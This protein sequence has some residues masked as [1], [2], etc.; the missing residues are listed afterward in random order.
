MNEQ[1]MKDLVKS[2]L[3]R[4]SSDRKVYVLSLLAHNLTISARGVYSERSDESE[5]IKK[6]QSLNEMQH[7]L[8][9]QLMYLASKDGD[10]L[11]DD[12]FTDCLYSFASQGGSEV[13][14]TSAL[15]YTLPF[16]CE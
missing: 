14:L 10:V 6:L 3:S 9:S 16:A 4:L 1:E 5:K 13:E 12:A 7:R 15:K 8:S 2:A 11:P